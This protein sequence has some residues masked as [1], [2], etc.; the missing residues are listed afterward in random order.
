MLLAYVSWFKREMLSL[1]TA[2]GIFVF[3]TLVKKSPR[4]LQ[5]A[6]VSYVRWTVNFG[7]IH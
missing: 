1:K 7:V 6:L 2:Q 3:E 4:C 5:W